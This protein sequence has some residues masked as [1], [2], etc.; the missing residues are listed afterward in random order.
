MEDLMQRL[1]DEIVHYVPWL[2][3]YEWILAVVAVV[4]LTAI[5]A[6]LGGIIGRRLVKSLEKTRHDW[7]N[8]LVDAL[9][10]PAVAMIWV[11]G[12]TAALDIMAPNLGGADQGVSARLR[13]VALVFCVGWAALRFVS[14]FEKI[15]LFGNERMDATTAD[16]IAKLLRLV[17]VILSGLVMLQTLGYS[18]SGLLAFGGIGGIAVGFA[19]K[20]LLANFFGGLMIYLD[21]P[22]QVGDWVRSP[23]A[24]IEGVVEAIG[25]RLTMIRTFD[26]RPLYVP[27]ATFTNIAVENPSRMLARRIYEFVGVRYDDADQIEGLVKSI[28]EMLVEH[29]DIDENNTLFVNLNRFGP[30]SLDIMIYT[31]THTTDWGRYL[32]I[33]ED[34][35]L[36]IIDIVD[37]AGAEI[38]FP[39]STVH[40]ASAPDGLVEP[41]AQTQA[42]T[43][44]RD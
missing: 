5:V 29:E 32:A 31:F 27:N 12:L 28:R 33:K 18:I 24:N 38:A 4:L 21:R 3:G 25:W 39:T 23:D 15:L 20:D 19:A 26:K 42:A 40:L 22:F 11:M 44:G 7:N 1:G 34:V 8:M 10:K 6:W 35:M 43:S 13:E 37:N 41:T 30:S 16:A 36:K 2:G 14:R 9:R 17:I